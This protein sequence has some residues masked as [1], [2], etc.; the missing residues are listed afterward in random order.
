MRA[1]VKAD[2]PWDLR[3]GPWG[4]KVLNL[5]KGRA[6]TV[7]FHVELG[8]VNCVSDSLPLRKAVRSIKPLFD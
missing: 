5:H 2:L 7:S 3:R 8:V 1:A 4:S 6:E